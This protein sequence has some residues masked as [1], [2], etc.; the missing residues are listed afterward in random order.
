MLL[1]F[2]YARA[3]CSMSRKTKTREKERSI[4]LLAEETSSR[5]H[6]MNGARLFQN[7]FLMSPST[8]REE[9]I[10]AGVRRR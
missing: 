4:M 5:D 2:L 1:N 6:V 10:A 7:C 8:A 3:G 9:A